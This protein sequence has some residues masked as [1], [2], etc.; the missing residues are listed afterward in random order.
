MVVLAAPSC[1][2]LARGPLAALEMAG[3]TIV[4]SD[5]TY[6]LA[7]EELS[8]FKARGAVLDDERKKITRPL[9][10]AKA[11]VMTL[12][13]GPAGMYDR[14]AE[15]LSDKMLGFRRAQREI[16]ESGRLAA[17]QAASVERAR[18]REAALTLEAEGRAGEAQ[19]MQAAAG[20]VVAA[21]AVSHAPMRVAGL[22]VRTLIDFE[23]TSLI[24]LVRQV[25]KN[26]ELIGLVEVN[27]TTMRK[28]VTSLGTAASLDGV[29]VFARESLSSKKRS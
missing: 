22:S 25:A 19:V 2:S 3:R 4:D 14:A 26:P 17:E 27:T 1:A 8:G 11:A 7:A 28:Y 16:A 5:E 6:E 13:R 18:L 21:P 12:F 15:I 20:M 9:D 24:D 29:R 10:E 23:V